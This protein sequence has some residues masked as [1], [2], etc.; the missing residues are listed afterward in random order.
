[1]TSTFLK[2]IALPFLFLGLAVSLYGIWRM[3]D[4]P[5]Q[6]ELI[7]IA[8]AYFER[9]G[10]IIVLASALIEGLLLVGWY[11]PGGLV[12]FLGVILAG[13]DETKVAAIILL[14]TLGLFL[15]YLINYFL[16]KYGW[17]RLLLAFGLKGPLENA[18]KRLARHGVGAVFLTCWQPNLAALTSTAAG[19]LHFSFRTF[20]LYSLIATFLGSAFWGTLVYLLGEAALSLPGLNFILV[21]IAVWIAFRLWRKEDPSKPPLRRNR[22]TKHPDKQGRSIDGKSFRYIEI[23]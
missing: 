21:T 6:E 16:G 8:R 7:E 11:Y 12:I 4:L 10:L 19:I 9:Y 22:R 2:R 20:A 23:S 5:T 14:V 17:Y 3:L 15:G 1:M 13:E 18:E